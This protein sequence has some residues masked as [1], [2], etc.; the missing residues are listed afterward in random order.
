V[1]RYGSD[2]GQFTEHVVHAAVG[3]AAV[4]YNVSNLGMKVMAKKA[5]ADSVI[6]MGT[7]PSAAASASQSNSTTDTQRDR[8]MPPAYSV[9]ATVDSITPADIVSPADDVT[10]ASAAVAVVSSAK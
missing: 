10:P 2:A 9:D 5:A 7:T 4:T 8:D 3:A 1:F 6:A